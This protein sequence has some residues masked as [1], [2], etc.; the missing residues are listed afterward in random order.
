MSFQIGSVRLDLARYATYTVGVKDAAGL[1]SKADIKIAGV[2]VGWVDNIHLLPADATVKLKLK[3]LKEYRLYTNALAIVRQEGMVGVKFL[4]VVPGDAS[5]D[6][7]L[8]GGSLSYQ[9]RQFVGMDETFYTIQ[10]IA[11]QIEDFNKALKKAADEAKS[12]FTDLRGSIGPLNELVSQL[13]RSTGTLSEDLQ[14]TIGSVRQ[15]ADGINKMIESADVPVKHIGE[16]AQKVNEGQGS[17]GQ[18]LADKDMYEDIKSTADFA[19]GCIERARHAAFMVDS[20]F[21]ILPHSFHDRSKKHD[22]HKTD[23]K[24]YFDARFYPCPEL[25]GQVGFAYSHRGFARHIKARCN[26]TLFSCIKDKEDSFRLNLQLG[27]WFYPGFGVR[28]GIFEGTAGVGLDVHLPFERVHWLTTFEAFDFRGHNRFRLDRRPHLK[29]MNR[30]FFN[31][32]LYLTFGAD[33]FISR[34]NRTGFVGAGAL[35]STCDLW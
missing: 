10:K 17:L 25:F 21:E 11:A 12:L 24:W 31:S 8:P 33:D 15:A 18:L 13:S 19:K 26:D 6:R 32:Y 29:W 14:A 5:Q 34:C 20:H 23:V 27:T 9:E 22:H 16:L 3:I 28:A 2:K 30:L 35:F 7:I 1:A 4:D